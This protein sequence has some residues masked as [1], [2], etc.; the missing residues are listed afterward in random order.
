M[1]ASARISLW[2]VKVQRYLPIAMMIVALFRWI[3]MRSPDGDGGT[4]L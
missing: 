1:T 2:S 3:V 4:G